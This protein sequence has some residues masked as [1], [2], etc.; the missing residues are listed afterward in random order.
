MFFTKKIANSKAFKKGS[1]LGFFKLV[2]FSFLILFSS[3]IFAEKRACGKSA[4]KI[5]ILYAVQGTGNGHLTRARELG[6]S[7]RSSGVQVDFIFSGRAREDFVHEDH[8]KIF[9]SDARYYKGLTFATENGKINNFKTLLDGIRY[10][11]QLIRDIKNL[12]LK[13]YDLVISDFEP[14]G[15]WAALFKKTPL[16]GIAHQY[17]FNHSK[18]P[19]S[20]LMKYIIAPSMKM[21]A[22]VSKSKSIGLHF[23]SFQSII[24]PPMVAEVPNFERIKGKVT[25]NLAHENQADV[26]KMLSPINSHDFHIYADLKKFQGIDLQQLPEHIHLHPTSYESYRRDFYSSQAVIVNAGFGNQSQAL[27]AGIHLLSKPING[28]PEQLANV[29]ALEQL[30]YANSINSLE[31]KDVEAWLHSIKNKKAV[32]VHYPNVSEILTDWI[33]QGAPV[34]DQNYVQAIW[35]KIL[36]ER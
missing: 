3:S 35:D 36:I 19:A 22:P 13:E 30:S 34:M 29:K 23:D 6:Q 33:L 2:L 9:G 15:A 26:V 31:T 16:Y 20:P 25:V 28:Q 27:K 4:G 21:L 17:S 24:L 8:D 5:K 12:Q 14:V 10:F 11:P 18:V 1:N 32:R 7:L